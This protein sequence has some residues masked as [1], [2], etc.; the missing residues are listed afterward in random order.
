MSTNY[1]A[2]GVYGILLDDI[3]EL[4]E[5]RKAIEAEF[6]ALRE[7]NCD[8]ES[9]DVND[10]VDGI[11]ED[12]ATDEI[13]KKWLPRLT[14]ELHLLKIDAP[15]GAQ[16]LYTGNEDERPGRCDVDADCW[17]LGF[18]MLMNPWS[19]PAIPKNFREH[20]EFYLWVSCG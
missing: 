20:A 8:N 13:N 7:G 19:W 6:A 5:M 10:M 12:K 17:V 16:M 15:D 14:K 4:E 9:L 11:D 3:P 1:F 2:N 18:G